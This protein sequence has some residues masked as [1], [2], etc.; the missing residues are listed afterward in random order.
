MA[1]PWRHHGNA[2]FG[3]IMHFRGNETLQC[4]GS[5]AVSQECQCG[6]VMFWGMPMAGCTSVANAAIP[7][8]KSPPSPPLGQ[9]SRLWR[10]PLLWAQCCAPSFHYQ[11]C[12]SGDNRH[13]HRRQHLLR[14]GRG[15]PRGTGHQASIRTTTRAPAV[16][17]AVLHCSRYR[18]HQKQVPWKSYESMAPIMI[19][20]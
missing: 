9:A 17:V 19:V 15:G 7:P 10:S 14:R 11:C 6:G 8:P 3:S 20:P 5:T 2:M 1:V 13:H 12:R 4:H 16:S 18:H